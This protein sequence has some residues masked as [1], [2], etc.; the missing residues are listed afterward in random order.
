MVKQN[1]IKNNKMCGPRYFLQMKYDTW[2]GF[3]LHKPN[4]NVDSFLPL[5]SRNNLVSFYHNTTQKEN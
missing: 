4:A 5:S 3:E 1:K 2:I